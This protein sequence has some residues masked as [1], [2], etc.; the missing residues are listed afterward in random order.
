MVCK[1]STVFC[2][3]QN[4]VEYFNRY[5]VVYFLNEINKTGQ[6]FI[7]S[8]EIAVKTSGAKQAAGTYPA[9]RIR[10][11]AHRFSLSAKVGVLLDE[12]LQPLFQS[13]IDGVDTRRAKI[14]WGFPTDYFRIDGMFFIVLIIVVFL[15][16]TYNSAE[17][18]RPASTSTSE[19][20]QLNLDFISYN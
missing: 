17:H 1:T 2:E 9:H 3:F 15:Y 5:V 19:T 7:F 16:L 4:N 13:G 14:F 8:Y 12:H 11:P 10:Y 20:Q 18:I 6:Y